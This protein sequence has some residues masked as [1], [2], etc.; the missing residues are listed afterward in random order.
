[1]NRIQPQ[2]IR[3]RLTAWYTA[4]LAVT[5][6]VVGIG[7]WL[8]LQHSIDSTID[9]E[10]RS[11]L[12]DVR[13]YVR[14]EAPAGGLAYLISELNEDSATPEAA[15]LRI[16]DASG[17]WIYRSSGTADWTFA[18]PRTTGLPWTGRTQ[19]MT[20]RGKPVRI[21]SAP[22]K[23]GVV[24]IGIPLDE[25][26]ELQQYFLWSA[27][28]GAPLLLALA[29]LGG[30]WMS[31]RALQPVDRIANAARRIGTRNLA[32]RLP[33]NGSGDEMD[34]LSAVL[35]EMLDRLESAFRRITQFT[36][37]ASHELR[38]P[39]AIIRTTAEITL[40]RR[41]TV[42]EHR[43][44]WDVVQA[45]A[46]RTSQLIH[47]LL[48][49]A[50]ADAASEVL[51]FEPLDI[52]QV[53]GDTCRQVAIMAEARGLTLGTQLE[54]G[55]IVFADP[56]ALRR[57]LLILLDNASK[58]T[59]ASGKIEVLTN[60]DDRNVVIEVRDTGIGIA[61]DDLPHIFE[62]FYRASK[63]RSRDSG[64]A[65]LGLSIAQSIVVRHEGRIT[66]ESVL[67]S[68]STFRVFLPGGTGMP[69]SFSNSSES[70]NILELKAKR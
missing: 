13:A 41:R 54:K 16:A 12:A 8:A 50:R 25:F 17:R 24:Q 59:P 58:Y 10:L 43:Q 4:I 3:F 18:A 30:F 66:V 6:A 68:G 63:D 44:A 55:L 40:S 27:A 21:I 46:E 29:A 48:A 52:S 7:I 5:F 14:R 53:V 47:D 70:E 45:Q 1:M 9:N 19:A 57:V 37:D 20:V 49:L 35:N 34:R 62:R 33:S 64:G 22:L 15:N 26:E 51:V 36:A 61:S 38:T 42:E 56:E 65:G 2:T 11:H 69:N 32:E 31:G 28:L 39:V 67:G 60:S 23:T